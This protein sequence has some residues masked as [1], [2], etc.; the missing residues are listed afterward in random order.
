LWSQ[1]PQI[2]EQA[3]LAAQRALELDPHN[4]DSCSFVAQTLNF[5]GRLE[6]ARKLS[7]TAIR[8]NPHYPPQYISTLGW[9]YLLTGQYEKAIAALAKAIAINPD[10]APPHVFLTILYSELGRQ[11]E[12][13]A[14]AAEILR[15]A[16]NFSLEF[17]RQRLPYK[18]ATVLE[19]Q[20]TALRKA[21]L[22]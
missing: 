11:E 6:E 22:Q 17:V 14:E 13:E 15:I 1:D 7:E 3:L 5:A 4:A 12:A 19:R 10:W 21:G 18:D 2:V 8:L 20:L 9:S 16:P